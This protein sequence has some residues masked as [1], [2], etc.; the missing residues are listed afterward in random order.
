MADQKD[1]SYTIDL[2]KLSWTGWLLLLVTLAVFLILVVITPVPQKGVPGGP[3]PRTP[4][5][6]I[7]IVLDLVVA[8]AFFAGARS[9]L[10]RLGLSIYRT[11]EPTQRRNQVPDLGQSMRIV[12]P[13]DKLPEPSIG[14]YSRSWLVRL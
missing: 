3:I 13:A 5:N 9:I 14:T 6:T 12:T 7:V 4:I 1:E 10:N 2:S 11:D 8:G